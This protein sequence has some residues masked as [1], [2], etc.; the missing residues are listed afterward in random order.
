[1]SGILASRIRLLR[2]IGFDFWREAQ[3]IAYH[4]KS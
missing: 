3:E 4:S 1:M 2:N